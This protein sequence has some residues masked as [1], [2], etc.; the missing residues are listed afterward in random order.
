VTVAHKMLDANDAPGSLSRITFQMSSA[1]FETTAMKRS[2]EL[3]GTEVAPVVRFLQTVTTSRAPLEA[4]IANTR[5]ATLQ[6]FSSRNGL[7]NDSEAI[8]QKYDRY[9]QSRSN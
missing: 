4:W 1:S 7:V 9:K 8:Q 5:H 3:L 6:H 2:I